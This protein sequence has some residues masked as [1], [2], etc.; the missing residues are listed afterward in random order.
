MTNA[1]PRAVAIVDDD[2]AVRESLQYLLGLVAGHVTETFVSGAEFLKS[3]MEHLGCVILDCHMPH[4]TGLELIE[5]LHDA[6]PTLLVTGSLSPDI[7]ARAAQ[8]G[9]VHVLEKPPAAE[10]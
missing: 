6:I 10:D 1:T 8:L 3:Q 4:M 7:A 9:V 2:D 5:R